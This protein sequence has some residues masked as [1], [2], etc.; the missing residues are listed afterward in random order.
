MLEE[1][2]HWGKQTLAAQ[3][4]AVLEPLKVRVISKGPATEYYLAKPF[5]V[6]LHNVLRRRPEF[7]L[8]GRPCSPT[9]LLDLWENRVELGEGE[10]CSFSIDYS[11]AT[12]NL[13]A[14][15]SKWIMEFLTLGYPDTWIN[16][17]LATLAPH[18]CIYPPTPDGTVRSVMQKTGQLMGSITSFPILCLANLGLYL[19]LIRDDPRPLKRKL[20]GVLVNGD[21]MG[22]IARVSLWDQH[23]DLGRRI[24]LEMSLG[25]AYCSAFFLNINSTCYHFDLTKE[26]V[27]PVEVRYLNSGLYFGQGKVMNKV[28]DLDQ[29]SARTATAVITEL[30]RGALPGKGCDILSLYLKKHEIQ[31]KDECRGRNL[32]LPASVGGMDQVAPPGFKVEITLAQRIL[33]HDLRTRSKRAS[34]GFGPLMAKEIEQKALTIRAPW[35]VK[36]KTK[37]DFELDRCVKRYW[38]RVRSGG[39]RVN[40]F[41]WDYTEPLRFCLWG[42]G[43]ERTGGELPDIVKE[44]ERFLENKRKFEISEAR[45]WSRYGW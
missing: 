19:R 8:I 23:V 38:K 2:A 11:A 17:W 34:I 1:S 30:V 6:A 35:L 20:K 31:I 26:P 43:Q 27:C 4:Q 36:G 15:L 41:S 5:Q 32:F 33:A 3:I 42:P 12:D 10:Y 22:Y 9:D 44:N 39:K 21:D 14:K 25:K 45:Y 7:R 28:S 24:G 29:E 18:Y 37:S 40:F 16:M 13:S